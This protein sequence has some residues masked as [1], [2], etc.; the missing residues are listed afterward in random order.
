MYSDHRYKE[1]LY[2]YYLYIHDLDTP[3]YKLIN[4][5]QLGIYLVDYRLKYTTWNYNV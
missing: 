3:G 4:K 2:I 5:Y 1:M